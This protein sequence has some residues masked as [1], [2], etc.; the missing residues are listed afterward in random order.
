MQTSGSLAG[1]FLELPR[2]F[3]G[4]KIYEIHIF[5]LWMKELINEKPPQ[6][7]MQLLNNCEKKVKK[8][9]LKLYLNPSPL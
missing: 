4:N 9:R 7:S 8:F 6:L 3:V 1:L 5:E 2:M